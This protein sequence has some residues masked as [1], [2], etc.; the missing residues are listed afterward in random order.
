MA[1]WV[2]VGC[3]GWGWRWRWW[4][5]GILSQESPLC[6]PRQLYPVALWQAVHMLGVNFV[7]LHASTCIIFVVFNKQ[8]FPSLTRTFHPLPSLCFASDRSFTARACSL[9]APWHLCRS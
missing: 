8:R 6:A 7:I 9:A 2:W 3:V 5:K 1:E 4:R